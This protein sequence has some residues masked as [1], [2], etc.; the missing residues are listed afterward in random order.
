MAS[1]DALAKIDPNADSEQ[2]I[3]DIQLKLNSSRDELSR[4]L[5]QRSTQASAGETALS[6]LD[7]RKFY[8]EMLIRNYEGQLERL[9]EVRELQQRNAKEEVV[10]AAGKEAQP[11]PFLEED[12]LRS[13]I[14]VLD[15][16]IAA[17]TKLLALIDKEIQRRISGI[18]NGN[19]RLRQLVEK[20]ETAKNDPASQALLNEKRDLLALQ[21][22]VDSARL[23]NVV[24]EK[25]LLAQK[26]LAA[27]RKGTLLA[28]QTNQAVSHEQLTLNDISAVRSKLE[29][30]RQAIMTELKSMLADLE[31]EKRQKTTES[32]V[33]A[34]P[35]PT[36]SAQ[37][38]ELDHALKENE[39]FKLQTL[40]MM[41]DLLEGQRFFW[42]LRESYAQVYDR[43]KAGEAYGQIQKGQNNL[44]VIREYVELLRQNTLDLLSAQVKNAE[45]SEASK[46]RRQYEALQ[47]AYIDRIVNFSRL[48]VMLETTENLISRWRQDLDERF[49][50]K[51]VADK[52]QEFWLSAL[53][54]GEIVW[55]YEILSAQDVTDI[56]GRKITIQRSIT[57]SKVCTAL[58]ILIFGYW[59]TVKLS[60]S[61]ERIA[62]MRFGMDI[63]LAR[64]ARR[65]LLFVAFIVLLTA[66]LMVVHIPLTV[67]AFMGGAVAIGAGFGMQNLLKNLMSGLM[68]ILERPFRP[69]DLVEV[70]GIRGRI[71][72]IGVR[73]SHIRD[74]NGIE[75][76]IP[77][78]I[79]IEERVTNW[80][81]SSQSVR[82]AVKV[83][84]AYGSPEQEVTD[85]LLQAADRH[86][87][88]LD[89]PAPQVLF[90][91]FGNDALL[92]GLYVWIE[93]KP[94]LDWRVV[95]S[96][97]R[98]MVSKTFAAK[99]ISIAFPQRDVHLETKQPL[100]VRI[101]N[102]SGL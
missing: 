86:G 22:R 42:E 47:T 18:E 60:R 97:L 36:S 98:Y 75:T 70:G 101:M 80:T 61:A 77:N 37:Q 74:A 50:V 34:A 84:V 49:R 48:L 6:N 45:S 59:L 94:S 43:E 95:A 68:L 26:L 56:D 24:I 11:L 76:L 10:Q 90:E 93:L 12:R 31:A 96:D 51:S 21:N 85:Y 58:M 79:F 29:N 87:L 41:L 8:L 65:W 78:S 81:L 67:F 92:F 62:T 102:G 20:L 33:A 35:F 64:I 4:V 17:M 13:D 2:L 73:S 91:D 63:N 72:D 53:A 52:L 15:K 40:Y 23:I 5:L 55:H 7:T 100:E 99:G 71:T 83:G 69:G 1:A 16:R 28:M 57:I 66:S 3:D 27:H 89:K 46:T 88:V 32:L 30:Q 9:D 19:A 14:A 25:Q 44:Q 54:L 82:I 38:S 39:G